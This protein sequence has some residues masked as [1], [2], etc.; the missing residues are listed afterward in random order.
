MLSACLSRLSL[1][2]LS[3]S[4]SQPFALLHIIK[5]IMSFQVCQYIQRKISVFTSFL[6][7]MKVKWVVSPPLIWLPVMWFFLFILIRS[8]MSGGIHVSLTYIVEG[9]ST[10]ANSS[11]SSSINNIA[12]FFRFLV[13]PFLMSA[14]F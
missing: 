11:K 12:I 6:L 14:A 1:E 2:L 7:I 9:V 4:L 8:L 10:F 5:E 13:P 3:L